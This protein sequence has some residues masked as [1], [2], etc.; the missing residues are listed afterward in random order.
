MF[1]TINERIE[2]LYDRDHKL[3]HSFF[4]PLKENNSLTKLNEIFYNNIIPLLQEYFYEDWEKIQIVL[5][6]HAKQTNKKWE[7]RL[8]QEEIQSEAKIIGFNHEDIEDKVKYTV[9]NKPIEKSYL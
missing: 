6:D 2:F 3:G 1:E 9:N 7:D 4:L 8:I 5:G